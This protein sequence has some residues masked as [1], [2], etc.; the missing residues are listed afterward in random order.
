MINIMSV[1][2][3]SA[4]HKF[5]RDHADLIDGRKIC[6]Q[7]IRPWLQQKFGLEHMAARHIRT[8]AIR[9]LTRQGFLRRVHPRSRWIEIFD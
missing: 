5:V 8:E 3:T 1:D 9:Q 6:R 2:Y 7:K 4:I